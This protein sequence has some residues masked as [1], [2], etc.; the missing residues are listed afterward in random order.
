MWDESDDIVDVAHAFVPLRLH[1]L[2]R[3]AGTFSFLL[4]TT[5]FLF[6]GPVTMTAAAA[7]HST[8]TAIMAA[9]PHSTTNVTATPTQHNE[10]DRD[11]HAVQQP[12]W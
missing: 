9:T 12:R 8:T 11:A 6:C 1:T 7:P 4:F 3:P 10:C 2:H 5:N